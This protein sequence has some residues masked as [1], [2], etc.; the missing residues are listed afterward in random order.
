L[1]AG[2]WATPSLPRATA[3]TAA[4]GALTIKRLDSTTP[5]ATWFEPGALSFCAGSLSPDQFIRHL[6][7]GRVFPFHP[8][9]NGRDHLGVTP[10]AI[11]MRLLAEL[12]RIGLIALYAGD[13]YQ[14]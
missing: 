10:S 7:A 11:N 9:L 4:S 1:V 3:A 13:W 8:E 2:S 12:T 5:G 6:T 14:A